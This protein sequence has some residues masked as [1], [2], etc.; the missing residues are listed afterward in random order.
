M[1]AIRRSAEH[2]VT[3]LSLRV[4]SWIIRRAIN[5]RTTIFG[6]SYLR[7]RAKYSLPQ[8]GEDEEKDAR[9][10]AAVER[11]FAWDA[12]STPV[13]HEEEWV[14][15]LESDEDSCS[16]RRLHLRI[17]H[18]LRSGTDDGPKISDRY[19]ELF[20]E[21]VDEIDGSSILIA[22]DKLRKDLA[23]VRTRYLKSVA[24]RIPISVK[25]FTY[26]IPI[27][28][29]TMGLGGYLYTSR[30]HGHFG[31]DVS[32]FFTVGDYLSSA[33]HAVRAAAWSAFLFVVSASWRAVN[34]LNLTKYE[35]TK[36]MKQEKWPRRLLYLFCVFGLFTLDQATAWFAASLWVVSLPIVDYLLDQTYRRSLALTLGTSSIFVFSAMLYVE[37]NAA[38]RR[39]ETG[40][41]GQDFS[42]VSQGP[43]L[44]SET[45]SI[46][47][48]SDR[49]LFLWARYENRVQVLPHTEIRRVS[50]SDVPE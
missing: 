22:H 1:S 21:D 24:W 33:V 19:R 6:I 12:G 10:K 5:T 30:V 28:S 13:E 47:G 32:H 11:F 46:I 14:Q 17:Q 39:I 49:Y 45:H 44:T 26:A 40:H 25:D 43:D 2:V 41:S 31:V 9:A 20:D 48:S 42:V 23:V 35:R 29:I 15:W 50:F 36:Y 16:N 18:W 7:L 37:S 3:R 34:D 27:L 4:N 8:L 38:I